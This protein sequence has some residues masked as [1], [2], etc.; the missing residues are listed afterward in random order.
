LVALSPT[1]RAHQCR[2]FRCCR[3]ACVPLTALV[4]VVGVVALV[5]AFEITSA[6]SAA[7][8]AL[9]VL[10][11][12]NQDF[13]FSFDRGTGL[14]YAAR[15]PS[16]PGHDAAAE[17]G[18]SNG[19]ANM[20]T[21]AYQSLLARSGMGK[22]L[23]GVAA[24]LPLMLLSDLHQLSRQELIDEMAPAGCADKF[25]GEAWS[26]RRAEALE[27]L[28]RVGFGLEVVS[29]KEIVGY[30]RS[31]TALTLWQARG[32]VPEHVDRARDALRSICPV[33][34]G[35]GDPLSGI[36]VLS[37]CPSQC[38]AQ[39]HAATVAVAKARM[40]A[41]IA[42]SQLTAT[43]GWQLF[44][45]DLR[46]SYGASNDL[47]TGLADQAL[48]S[49]CSILREKVSGGGELSHLL[50]SEVHDSSGKAARG[51]LQAFCPTTCKMDCNAS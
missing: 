51:S 3:S 13:A 45:H 4:L 15:T 16:W 1:A 30:C 11:D 22:G 39:R 35:C 9:G 46:Q 40:C 29:C 19:N 21:Y 41:D 26:P 49:G 31:E 37:G 23:P 20:R 42:Q 27:Q 25:G 28:L 17:I 50:C 8:D 7:K 48:T 43:P 6:V 18:S 32:M 38:F 34:C 44:F 24:E 36:Y 47:D 33:T 12:E 14:I 2:W 10:C 5:D